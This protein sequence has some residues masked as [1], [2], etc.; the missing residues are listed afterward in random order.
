M[1]TR[2]AA[3][4]QELYRSRY[5][6]FVRPFM[7]EAG[8]SKIDTSCLP[9]G[10]QS[11]YKV[12]P[13][14]MSLQKKLKDTVGSFSAHN[15]MMLDFFKSSLKLSQTVTERPKSPRDPLQ[16]IEEESVSAPE[17]ALDADAAARSPPRGVPAPLESAAPRLFSR[18]P[19]PSAAAR[20]PQ[21]RPLSQN[22][23][24]APASRQLS[25]R[26]SAPPP[27]HP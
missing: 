23:P 10:L 8:P 26:P 5:G 7:V 15:N 11:K 25:A 14:K 13:A 9:E 16:P 27:P 3:D 20:P 19:A 4:A 21:S 12:R 24:N 2:D 6:E 18:G 17:A 22:A 1:E